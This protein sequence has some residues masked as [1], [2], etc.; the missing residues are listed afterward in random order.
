[1]TLRCIHGDF[2]VRIDD[3]KV[4][5]IKVLD[6]FTTDTRLDLMEEHKR[7]LALE[8]EIVKKRT[9][10][11]QDLKDEFKEFSKEEYPEVFL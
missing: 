10:I 9:K 3:L 11:L 7:L 6:V 1:M 5:P 4:D 8:H 2:D